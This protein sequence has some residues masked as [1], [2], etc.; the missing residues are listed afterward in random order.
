MFPLLAA[1]LSAVLLLP[2]IAPAATHTVT[3]VENVFTPDLLTIDQ[4]D[5]VVFSLGIDHNVSEVSQS[6]WEL[7]G[8]APLAGGFYAGF[9]GDT[10]TG[11]AAGTHYYV[12]PPH[13]ESGMKGRIIVNPATGVGP[14][15]GPDAGSGAG[16][17][18]GRAPAA[19]SLAQNYPNPFNPSTAIGFSLART[20]YAEVTVYDALGRPVKT[21]VAGTLPAGQHTTA[22]DGTDAKGEAA[23]SGAYFI[24]MSAGENGRDYFGTSRILLIR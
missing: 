15:A 20:G 19:F 18:A 10:V 16:P 6:T 22:W 23:G 3:N 4:G 1:V 9:G 5:T 2:A 21:L 11:L 17:G 14:E 8:T 12:C 24:V 7:N 13:V